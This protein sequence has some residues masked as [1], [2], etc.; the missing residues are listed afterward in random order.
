LNYRN[1]SYLGINTYGGSG[2]IWEE[3]FKTNLAQDDRYLLIFMRYIELNPVRADM[4]TSPEQYQWSSFHRN[5]R[6]G[7]DAVVMSHSLHHKLGR[8][9]DLRQAACVELFRA[10]V[11]EFD[12]SETRNAWQTGTPLGND[13]FRRKVESKLGCIVGQSRRGRPKFKPN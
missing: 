8:T 12:L 11:D 7:K 4:V 6:G 5:G 9:K 2:S 10:H 3:R 1:Q 13:Y